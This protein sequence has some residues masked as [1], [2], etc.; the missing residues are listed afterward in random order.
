[1]SVL[2]NIG[3][4]IGIFVGAINPINIGIFVLRCKHVESPVTWP[5][6]DY[7]VAVGSSTLNVACIEGLKPPL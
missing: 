6:A 1:M 7:S 4:N 3:V 2:N 5:A